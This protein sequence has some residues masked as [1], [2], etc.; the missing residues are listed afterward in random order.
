M[1]TVGFVV[2]LAVVSTSSVSHARTWYVSQSGT[3]DMTSISAAMDSAAFG[4]TVLVAAG[5]Y[6]DFIDMDD[7]VTLRSESGPAST[8]LSGLWTLVRFGWGISGTLEGFTL[9]G[10]PYSQVWERG[11]VECLDAHDVRILGN[12]ITNSG[13]HGIYCSYC[14]GMEFGGNTIAD[15]YGDGPFMAIYVEYSWPVAIHHNICTGHRYGIGLETS[16][17]SLDCNDS[18]DNTFNYWPEQ[19]ENPWPWGTN[20]SEDPRFCARETKD[21]SLDSCSPCLPGNDPGGAGCGQVGALG[22]G[23]ASPSPTETESWSS[24]KALYR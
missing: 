15:A 7:G 1:R 22:Q 17:G 13:R 16:G 12:V 6:T 19:S 23:C 18:W 9:T 4:D 3:G 21:Y 2:F 11:V 20:F 24:I 8:V 5:V 14:L 10:V